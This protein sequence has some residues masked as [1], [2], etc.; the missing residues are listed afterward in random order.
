LLSS[1]HQE[2]VFFAEYQGL[3]LAAAVVEYFGRRAT[4]FFGGSLDSHR[5]V[6]APYL[7]HFEIMR[8]AKAMG[9]EWYDLWGVAPEN[10]PAH[11]V[12]D[13]LA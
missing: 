4:Y 11:Y 1:L 5:H 12:Y 7:L 3:R 9:R 10:E 13:T 8:R 2:S 6:M